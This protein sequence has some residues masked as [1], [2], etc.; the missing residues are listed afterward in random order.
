MSDLK[1]KPVTMNARFAPGIPGTDLKAL[2]LEGSVND[3]ELAKNLPAG[4]DGLERPFALYPSWNQDKVEWRRVDLGY[5]SPPNNGNGSFVPSPTDLYFGEGFVTE[6]DAKLIEQQGV[7]FGVDT[8]R[9]TF[10][11]QGMGDNLIPDDK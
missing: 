9:G 11:L 6:Q 8:N 3:K 5:I 10:W 4:F 2:V 1:T 7:A